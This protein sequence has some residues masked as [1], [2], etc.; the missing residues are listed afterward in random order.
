MSKNPLLA[1]LS[2]IKEKN[3]A[4][5]GPSKERVAKIIPQPI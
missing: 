4:A 3:V 1:G 2:A 5:A